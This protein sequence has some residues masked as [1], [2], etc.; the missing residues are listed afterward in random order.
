MHT[1]EDDL[2]GGVPGGGIPV[3]LETETVKVS[4]QLEK[5]QYVIF[6]TFSGCHDWNITTVFDDEAAC[7]ESLADVTSIDKMRLVRVALPVL[8]PEGATFV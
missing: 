8:T 5:T 6:Y 1:V 7:V 2:I 4:R 3:A